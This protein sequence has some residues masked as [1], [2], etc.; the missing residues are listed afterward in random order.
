MAKITLRRN[1]ILLI[2]FVGLCTT[3]FVASN[4]KNVDKIIDDAIFPVSELIGGIVFFSIEVTE[5]VNVPIVVIWL[6]LAGIYF[7]L[8]FRFINF[9]AFRHSFSLLKKTKPKG[10]LT[11]E[12]SHLQALT[13]AI[14]GT[15][16]LGNIAGVAIAISIGGP[17][18]TLW[19]IVA[20]LLGMSLKFIECTLAVKFRKTFED[21]TVSGGPM[22]YL[23]IGLSEKGWPRTGAIAAS[24]FA[25]CC[26][27]ASFGSGNMFQANQTFKQFIIVTGGP[28]SSFLGFGWIFGLILSIFVGVFII[29][30]IKRIVKFTQIVV[31]LMALVYL[32]SGAIILAMHYEMIPSALLLIVSEAFSPTAVKGGMI[33]ALIVGFQRSAFSNEA[34]IG[35]SAIAHSAVKTDYPVTQGIVALYEPFIDTVVFCTTTALVIVVTGTFVNVQGLTG[36]ELTSSAFESVISWFPFLLAITVF[37]FAISSMVS[38][39]YY[40]L[41]SWTFLFGE[42]V[43]QEY[44][45]KF[46]F[47]AF[48]ILGSSMELS[49]VIHFS[50]A[51]LFAMCVPNIFGLYWLAPI[52][53]EELTKYKF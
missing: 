14:S 21:G 16:G 29:G 9:R 39:S 10:S 45:Y 31:P 19:M 38:W 18:A 5:G 4:F 2:F 6:I 42:G 37:L 15:V 13:T 36:I 32:T 1:L 34:G 35:S 50:D 33:G 25:F 52:V 41:K 26:V 27:L 46:V 20:G 48:I 7:T 53:Q 49:S 23:S 17:G 40:G 43:L 22:Y 24:I 44:S 47:L 8:Y 12:I 51:M 30:G 3:S 28:Q 11:G